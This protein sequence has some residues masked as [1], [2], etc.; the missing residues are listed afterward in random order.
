MTAV[1]F[2]STAFIRVYFALN[3]MGQNKRR[4]DKGKRADL[5]EGKA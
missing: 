5:K 3:L 4:G 2:K 1:R